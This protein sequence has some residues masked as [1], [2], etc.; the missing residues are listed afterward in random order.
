MSSGK[1]QKDSST[2]EKE[3]AKKQAERI[4]TLADDKDV[5]K[6]AAKVADKLENVIEDEERKTRIPTSTSVLQQQQDA[7]IKSL[8]RTKDIIKTLAKE[9]RREI[10]RY[11][12]IVND[13]Q[14]QTIEAARAIAENQIESQKE[15]IN[16]CQSPW[17][18][19]VE[20]TNGL[21]WNN[22]MIPG[23]ITETYANMVSSF[24]N[25]TI[26][27]TRLVNSMIF[28]NMDAF[29]AVVEQTKDNSKE[30]LRT[31]TNNTAR[32]FDQTA[33]DTKRF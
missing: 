3:E 8:D 7:V 22:W 1:E 20:N 15:T 16:L 28:A 31:G 6:E 29:K 23:S 27:A 10:T 21:F 17:L 14:E 33:R 2:T 11:T 5:R 18:P 25:I 30:L 26:A 19:Y 12:Q 32:M 24:A 4:A 9:T 13:Y